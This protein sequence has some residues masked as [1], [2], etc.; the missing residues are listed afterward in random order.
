MLTLTVKEG[1]KDGDYIKIGDDIKIML[2]KSGSTY[3]LSI[4]APKHIPILRK[5]V[6]DDQKAAAAK[7]QASS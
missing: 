5:S 7:A 6:I 4:D 3:R 2:K 1:M